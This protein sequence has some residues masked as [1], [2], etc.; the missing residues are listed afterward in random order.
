MISRICDWSIVTVV[1]FMD[2]NKLIDSLISDYHNCFRDPKTPKRLILRYV[3]DVQD[4]L[5]REICIRRSSIICRMINM[6]EGDAQIHKW[7]KRSEYSWNPHSFH[8]LI[9]TIQKQLLK[10]Y[11]YQIKF[12]KSRCNCHKRNIK[13]E[14]LK[15]RFGI[16]CLLFG[17]HL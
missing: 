11:H 6:K 5:D 12:F 2:V 8:H 16:L 7:I 13:S 4:I 14:S 1:T 10:E 17:M 15:P 9:L 3:D